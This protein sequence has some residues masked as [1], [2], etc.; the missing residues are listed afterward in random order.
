MKVQQI[1]DEASIH[2]TVVYRHFQDRADLDLALQ[3]EICRRLEESLIAA[4]SREGKPR[5]RIHRF[6]GAQVQWVVE[7]PSWMRFAGRELSSAGENPL[8]EVINRLGGQVQLVII[9]FL[10]V[11]GG[12]LSDADGELL[13]PWIYGLI[14]GCIGAARNWSAR[15]N[16]ATDPDAL[17]AALTESTW[18]QID[19]LASMRGLR[20]PDESL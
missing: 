3:R 6:V 8:D 13:T 4:V 1:A 16:T 14:T 11:A 19:G 2:R 20:V 17:T 12:E 15:D 9:G 5:E 7:H 18:L 10:G